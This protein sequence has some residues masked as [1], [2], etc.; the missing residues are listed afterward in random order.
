MIV[1]VRIHEFR[2]MVLLLQRDH[3]I[4][5]RMHRCGVIVIAST[6]VNVLKWRC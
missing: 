5:M 1:I 4:E 2:P 6:G 3:V